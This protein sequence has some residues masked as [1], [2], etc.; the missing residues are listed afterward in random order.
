[1]DVDVT[2][3]YSDDRLCEVAFAAQMMR[4]RFTGLLP[5][6][7][8]EHQRSDGGKRAVF[9]RLSLGRRGT[10]AAADV[11]TVPGWSPLPLYNARRSPRPW[12]S[13]R[14]RGPISTESC[15]ACVE[16]ASPP[17]A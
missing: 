9:L 15:A 4:R 2:I 12:R 8:R 6:S 5:A 11:P 16:T 13:C 7:E 14:P 10:C 1:M 3:R 17:S